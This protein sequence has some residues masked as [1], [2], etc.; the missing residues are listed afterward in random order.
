MLGGTWRVAEALPQLL[1]R[2]RV[3][4]DTT[5]EVARLLPQRVADLLCGRRA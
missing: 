4:D 3:R 1:T 2:E 5:C